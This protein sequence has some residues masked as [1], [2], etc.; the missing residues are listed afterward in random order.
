MIPSSRPERP[1][2]ERRCRRR[3]R[4]RL[5]IHRRAGIVGRALDWHVVH[6]CRRGCPF[7]IRF[8]IVRFAAIRLRGAVL[9]ALPVVM[10]PVVI[11]LLG[12]RGIA[13]RVVARRTLAVLAAPAP[14]AP[15][16][17]AAAAVAI[18]F[19]IGVTLARG[20][21]GL[22][23]AWPLMRIVTRPLTR[24]AVLVVVVV[25]S[26]AVRAM[27]VRLLV[28]WK[29][30]ARGL[31][32]ISAVA[33]GL[34]VTTRAPPAPTTAAATAF[35]VLAAFAGRFAGHRRFADVER[36]GLVG[37]RSGLA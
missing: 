1:P 4:R 3:G 5:D 29:L 2:V 6:R 15:A 26:R 27:I 14:A 21:D 32:T 24:L 8:G 17:A 30:L 11:V 13:R 37:Q 34:A 25:G 23:F 31:R 18:A 10:L 16:S 36:I 19:T 28:G 7:V 12:G 9:L 20:M 35:L 22:A 33:F